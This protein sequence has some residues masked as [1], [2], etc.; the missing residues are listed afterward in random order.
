M[1]VQSTVK[2]VRIGDIDVKLKEHIKEL[3]ERHTGLEVRKS[4]EELDKIL[5]DEFL[6]IG[7]SGYMFGKKEMSRI[8]CCAN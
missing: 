1:P 3:E 7:S 2:N 5:A 4:S 6:E 8:W